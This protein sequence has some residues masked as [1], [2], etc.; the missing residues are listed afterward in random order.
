MSTTTVDNKLKN[1]IAGKWVESSTE[2][3]EEIPN[4][5]TGERLSRV[6]LSTK[7]D[8]EAAVQAAKEAFPGWSA[9]PVVER[10]RVMFRFQNLLFQHQ[11]E[12]AKMITLE[13]G[14]NLPEAFAEILRGIE[15]VEFAAGMPTLLMGETL[16]NIA[17]SIDSQSIRFPL[18]VVAGITPFNF[19]VMVPMWMYP[20][21][22]TAGNTFVLKPSERTPLSCIRIVE[23]LKEAGLPDGVLNIVNGAHDVVNGLLEHPDVK[24]ISFVGSQPV[25]EYVYKTAAANGKRV[26]AL[27]GAKNH[28][29]V[30][31][32]T[33]LRRAAK[34]IV[35]S[36]FG[37][38][39]ERCMAAS[40]VVAVEEIAD[41]LIQ[42]LIEESD[43]LHMGNG[44]ENGIDLGPVI[45]SSHLEKVHG[46]I[47]RGLESGAELVLDGRI[48]PATGDQKGYFLGPTIFDKADAQMVIVRDEIFAPVLSVMRVKSF[49][50]G[51]ETI[52]KSRFGN[53]ATIYTNSGRTGREF[54]QRVEAGMVGVNVGVPA[55]MGFFA[56]SGWKQSFYGDLHCNGKDGVEFYTKKKT[57]TSRWFDDGDTGIGS[58]K[59]FVK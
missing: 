29:L 21:A 15:M 23:L 43:A 20:I 4:P 22:I 40:A 18:G 53:G 13:N 8:V 24:G 27:A 19:P 32:D 30:M 2:R 50:E 47:E 58:Q 28:H 17:K 10:A 54:V 1:Y 35:S 36:A 31:A 14:K 33:D 44:L 9:T 37:C 41:E 34:T 56:F 42:Y 5:A 52:S 16:P 55:P 3:Y 51:L 45:R 49:E 12:L 46:Y 25:A 57:V 48:T 26:Q 11:E 39:G 6:P 7:A 38:A 59:V